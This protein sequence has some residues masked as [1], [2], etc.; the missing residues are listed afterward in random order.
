MSLKN[1]IEYKKEYYGFI[2]LIHNEV[3]GMKY[4]GQKKFDKENRWKSY[5]GGGKILKLA[6]EKYGINNFKRYLLDYSFS[7]KDADEKEYYYIKKYKAVESKEFYNMVDGGLENSSPYKKV[8]LVNIDTGYVFK[9]MN[10]AMEWSGYTKTIIDKS[11]NYKHSLDNKVDELIFKKLEFVLY[12]HKLCCLCAKNI[13]EDSYK[14]CE[15]CV[16]NVKFKK[17]KY[18]KI[19]IKRNELCY[20][21]DDVWVRNITKNN[22][23]KTKLRKIKYY[24]LNKSLGQKLPNNIMKGGNVN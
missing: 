24:E 18:K 23:I 1:Q 11:L 6:Q 2:Y 8:P 14:F 9:S 17:S 21:I 20:D 13:P 7:K 5:M 22:R 16:N 3:N 12:K 4:I 19:H 10:D 15:E